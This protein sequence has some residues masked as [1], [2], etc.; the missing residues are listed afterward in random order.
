MSLFSGV[1]V[2]LSQIML[3]SEARRFGLPVLLLITLIPYFGFV[4]L[5]WGAEIVFAGYFVDRIIYLIFFYLDDVVHGFRSGN[6]NSKGFFRL[7]FIF[8]VSTYMILQL[9]GLV[10]MLFSSVLNTLIT[11]DLL[12]LLICFILIYGFQFLMS[13]KNGVIEHWES[14][15]LERTVGMILLAA[16]TIMVP[17]FAGVFLRGLIPQEWLSILF[18]SGLEIMLFLFLCFRFAAEAWFLTRNS[19]QKSA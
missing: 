18:K 10:F 6:L 19:V 15:Y 5:G 7:T 13:Q 2:R 16:V 11:T 12:Y 9:L 17:L 1:L 3:F 8:L 4:F 14:R